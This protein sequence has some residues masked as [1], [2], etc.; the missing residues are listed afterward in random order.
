M[1]P[2]SLLPKIV[3]FYSNNHLLHIFDKL[4]D[5]TLV[6]ERFLITFGLF[7]YVNIRWLH[8]FDNCR[9]LKHE[10]DS[11]MWEK[12]AKCG[13]GLLCTLFDSVT[14]FLDCIVCTMHK[15][16][17]EVSIH[18]EVIILLKDLPWNSRFGSLEIVCRYRTKYGLRT[19][20]HCR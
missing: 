17:I 2:S 11:E 3:C 18:S 6:G 9:H 4:K 10:N 13:R 20:E 16:N 19:S 14:F 8:T 15:N 7:P 1:Y 12:I 5:T